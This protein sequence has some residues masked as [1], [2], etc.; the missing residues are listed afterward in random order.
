MEILIFLINMI[1]SCLYMWTFC[2]FFIE[3][4]SQSSE[5]KNCF[6]SALKK[7]LIFVLIMSNGAVIMYDF[8][9]IFNEL[10]N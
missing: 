6:K 1:S 7:I 3:E 5:R 4:I 9:M 10:Y 8:C 2:G